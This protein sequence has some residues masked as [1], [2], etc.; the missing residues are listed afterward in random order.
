L[1][2]AFS[3]LG[4]F[5]PKVRRVVLWMIGRREVCEGRA[6]GAGTSQEAT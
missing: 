3:R 5:G 4:A 2:G 1:G 6:F